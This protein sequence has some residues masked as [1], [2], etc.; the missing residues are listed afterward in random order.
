V[1]DTLRR[2]LAA[3]IE[4]QAEAAR[5]MEQQLQI[6]DALL[7]R[8]SDLELE[9]NRIDRILRRNSDKLRLDPPQE[10]P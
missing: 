4:N 2:I 1:N 6:N 3:M 7:R 9:L 5:Q 8:V 10:T